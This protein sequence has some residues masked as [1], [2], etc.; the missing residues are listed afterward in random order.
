MY[1]GN[2]GQEDAI[3]VNDGEY[4]IKLYNSMSDVGRNVWNSFVTDSGIATRMYVY[5]C[6]Y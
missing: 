4:T 1:T 3:S 5:V 2:N 6:I